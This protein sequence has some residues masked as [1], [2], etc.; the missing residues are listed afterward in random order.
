[1]PHR[2]LL[3]CHGAHWIQLPW[4]VPSVSPICRPHHRPRFSADPGRLLPTTSPSHPHFTRTENSQGPA[5]S[6]GPLPGLHSQS[7][8]PCQHP[9]RFYDP[10]RQGQT[11]ASREPWPGG[12]AACHTPSATPGPLTSPPRV[13]GSA[14]IL[15]PRLSPVSAEAGPDFTGEVRCRPSCV[16]QDM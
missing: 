6:L 15:E 2:G 3:I 10:S 16:A 8:C 7:H 9:F 14:R 12:C 11:A 4:A 1:M 5:W 13:R